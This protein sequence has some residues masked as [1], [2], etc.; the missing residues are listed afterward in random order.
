MMKKYL[1]YT[2]CAVLAVSMTGCGGKDSD[3]SV[4][5]QQ[6]II[7]AVTESGAKQEIPEGAITDESGT[8]YYAGPLQQ[9]GDSQNG[10]IQLPLGFAPFQAEGVENS[11]GVTQY[12]N[13]SGTNLVTLDRYNVD[14]ATSATTLRYYM[15]ED[16]NVEGLTG[17]SVTINGYTALQIYCHYKADNTFMV[18]WCIEDPADPKSSYYLAIQFTNEDSAVMACSST[19]QTVDDFTGLE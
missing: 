3:K 19:F 15:E 10:Y 4:L 13:A 18:A 11:E 17:A 1:A 2:L 12:T 7:P 14:Y 9:F 5:E 16:E 8:F 6:A